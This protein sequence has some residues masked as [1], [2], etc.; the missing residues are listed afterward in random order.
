MY[1]YAAFDD[2]VFISISFAKSKGKSGG[3]GNL[4]HKYSWPCDELGLFLVQEI[5]Q[6]HN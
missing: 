5:P 2:S 6:L 4:L 3:S 1:P